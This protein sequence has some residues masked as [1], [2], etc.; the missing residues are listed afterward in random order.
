[1][2]MLAGMVGAVIGV[3]THRDHHT[4]AVVDPTGAALT[5][6]ELPTDAFGYR[7]MLAFARDHAPGRRVWPSKAP[8]ASV[9]A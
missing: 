3:D 4:V 6:T 1:M 2:S 9:P 5:S 8:A 7:R